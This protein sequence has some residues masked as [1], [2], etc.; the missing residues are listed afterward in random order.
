VGLDEIPVPGRDHVSFAVE[1]DHIV[2]A[3]VEHVDPVLAVYR[4]TSGLEDFVYPSGILPQS[5][6]TSYF[7]EP[8][9]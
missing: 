6:S 7:R 1:Y 2:G 8:I 5:S 9:V 3:P 4:D